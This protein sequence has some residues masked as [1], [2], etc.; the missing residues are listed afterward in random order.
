MTIKNKSAYFLLLFLFFP[1]PLL[2]GADDGFGAAQ[3]V[4]G[5]YF[6]IYYARPLDAE[7]LAKKLNVGASERL[8]AG[9][10]ITPEN[11]AAEGLNDMV[12][13]LFMRVS[14]ILDMHIYSF[15]GKIKVCRNNAELLR[16]YANLHGRPASVLRSFYSFDLDTIYISA[17]D[18]RLEILGHEMAHA[19]ISRYFA[20]PA[21]AK[22][23]EVLSGYVEYQLRKG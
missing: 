13:T 6:T 10:G 20:V 5:E 11:P 7:S 8:L 15:R 2:F 1:L 19:L 4:K 23:S 9:K 3:S 21:P 18:F 12:D 17:D 22:A 16:V 14:D